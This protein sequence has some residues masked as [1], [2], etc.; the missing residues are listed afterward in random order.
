[1]SLSKKIRSKARELGFD[2]VGFTPA[3]PLQG[4]RFYARWIALGFAGEM[5][6]LKRNLDKRADP[7]QMVPGARSVI[8]LGMNY[9]QETPPPAHP[10]SGKIACYARG[11]DYHD[12]IKKRLFILWD[13]IRETGGE[14]STSVAVYISGFQWRI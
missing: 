3:D 7:A 1:M 10:L 4:A 9:Y 12:L 6:Y 8:C 13:W 11:D 14:T 2:L 5:N